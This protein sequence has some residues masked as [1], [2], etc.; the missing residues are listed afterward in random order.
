LDVFRRDAAAAERRGRELIKFS[1]DQ[2]L[3]VW[4][5]YARILHGWAV[6]QLYPGEDGIEAINRGLVDFA[7]AA[8]TLTP[9]RSL[10]MG[11]MKSFLLSLLADGYRQAHDPDAGLRALDTACS[12]IAETHERF[13]HAEVLRL[14]GE[15]FLQAGDGKVDAR[16]RAETCFQEARGI[17]ARQGARALELRAAI[18]LSRL[19][20]DD[21]PE[22]VA[23]LLRET[24]SA[25]TEG[26][27]TEDQREARAMMSI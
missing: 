8:S 9:V 16:S 7:D 2:N 25:F 14:R 18:S 12:F 3:R 23:R 4:V 5:A 1:E 24:C 11:F 20:R 10:Q 27:D 21:R 13:W 26:F 6:S 22:A 17:A 15:L 19:W